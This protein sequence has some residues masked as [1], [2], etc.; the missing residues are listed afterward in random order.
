MFNKDHLTKLGF[1]KILRIK[2]V[3]PKGLNE[4]IKLIYPKIKPIIKPTLVKSM[5]MLNLY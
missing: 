4:N 3:F 1:I 2:S 5:R